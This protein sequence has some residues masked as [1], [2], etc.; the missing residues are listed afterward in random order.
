MHCKICRHVRL[1][2]RLSLLV[3]SRTTQLHALI[4]DQEAQLQVASVALPGSCN[5][6]ISRALTHATPH[7]HCSAESCDLA[8]PHS[9]LSREDEALVFIYSEVPDEALFGARQE[10]QEKFAT[11]GLPLECPC[12]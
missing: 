4:V 2:V 3:A 9:T 11:L 5:D 7:R 12:L 8:R 6:Y 1:D 10:V